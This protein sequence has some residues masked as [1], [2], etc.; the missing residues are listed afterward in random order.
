MQHL[1]QG[2]ISK[3]IVYLILFSVWIASCVVREM[4]ATPTKA[5]CINFLSTTMDNLDLGMYENQ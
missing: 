1:Q 4:E 5:T 2:I 3:L